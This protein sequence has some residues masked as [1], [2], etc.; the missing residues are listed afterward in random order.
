MKYLFGLGN[1]G[2]RYQSSRHNTGFL[3]ADK[4]QQRL[5]F[6]E[7]KL[8]S[9]VQALVSK[10]QQLIIA[11]PQTF[12]NESGRAVQ[13]MLNFYNESSLRNVYIAHDDLDLALGTYKIQFGKGPKIHNGVNSVTQYLKSDQF[14]HVRI[15]IDTRQNDRSIP[16]Q[17]AYSGRDYVLLPM[18]KEEQVLLDQTLAEVADQLVSSFSTEYD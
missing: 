15:G 11:K 4:L 3:L 1:P 9:K 2:E 14:W 13:S 16:R 6:P 7:F 17:P 18:T 10:R 5:E 8:Q 12:M